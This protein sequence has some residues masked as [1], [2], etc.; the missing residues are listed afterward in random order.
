MTQT[1]AADLLQGLRS[2]LGMR[3]IGS[4]MARLNEYW[5]TFGRL[6]PAD[7]DAPALLC[8]VAQWVDAGWRDIDV[9]QNGLCA[10]PKGRRAELRLLDYA[11]VLMAEGI[12]WMAEENIERTITNFNLVLSFRNEISDPQLLALA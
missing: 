1:A 4:G 6:D 7:P 5:A 8:Y 2:D 12:I 11:H 10:F 3:R 9:V